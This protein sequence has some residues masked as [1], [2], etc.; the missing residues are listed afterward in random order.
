MQRPL[1]RGR[2]PL[3]RDGSATLVGRLPR[4]STT[5]KRSLVKLGVLPR[6]SRHRAV[7]AA[8]QSLVR[9][10]VLP[11]PADAPT[12]FGR[13]RAFVRRVARENLWIVY[14]VSD[15]YVDLLTVQAEPPLPADD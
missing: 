5:F 2:G 14:K 7:G 11:A 1:R 10:E 4:L 13:G 3:G 6:T 8:V 9:A 12:A 15:Q